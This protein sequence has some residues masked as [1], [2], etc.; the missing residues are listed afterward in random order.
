M[1]E[2]VNIDQLFQKAKTQPVARSFEKTKNEF[3]KHL[4]ADVN[5]PPSDGKGSFFTL[6]NVIIMISSILTIS[7]AAILL[8]PTEI[9]NKPTKE[10]IEKTKSAEEVQEVEFII[11]ENEIPKNKE[12][13]WPVLETKSIESV[14]YFEQ[15]E[16]IIRKKEKAKSKKIV[17]PIAYSQD[18]FYPKLT[19]EEIE[20]NHKQKKKMIK[21]L[22]KFD[23]KLYAYIPSGSFDYNSK[24]ISIQAFYMQVYE[25]TNLEYR[26]F[27]F[28]LL[29][30][31]KKAEFDIAKPEQEK[32]ST[33]TKQG[34]NAYEEYYFSHTAYDNYPVVNISREAAEMYCF[35]LSN[36]TNATLKDDEK[37]ND[38]RIPTRSEWVKAASNE[39]QYFDYPWGNGSTQNNEGEY[40]ANYKIPEEEY[41]TLDS[42]S[43]VDLKGNP[44]DLTAPVKSYYPNTIGLYNLSGNVAEM[45]YE[46]NASKNNPGTAGGSWL[47]S[48]VEIK[49]SGTDPYKGV[50]SGHPG[51]GFR[52]VVAHLNF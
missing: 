34:K 37:I 45:V 5:T 26:T 19:A 47:N 3:L 13:I 11:E 12:L 27:L 21:S 43:R 49:I 10:A 52:I 2:Q 29:I 1:K 22:S 23:K 48:E 39:G 14:Q 44:K 40:L 7:I 9:N 17:N 50:T 41:A 28:D 4:S 51:I 6:K 25:V 32:W 15:I 20:A 18:K 46:D 35:W 8:L 33:L 42:T 36:E 31:G 24:T 30:Q 16:L 38:V